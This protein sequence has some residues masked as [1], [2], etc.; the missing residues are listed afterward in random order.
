MYITHVHVKHCTFLM[1]ILYE[2]LDA[3]EKSASEYDET[4]AKLRK[5]LDEER[6]KKVEAINKLAQV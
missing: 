1:C 3:L 2:E 4:K 5:T 6:I